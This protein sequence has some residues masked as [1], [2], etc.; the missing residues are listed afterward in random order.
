MDWRVSITNSARIQK[1]VR[2]E[3]TDFFRV[4][5]VPNPPSLDATLTAQD[6]EYTIR[7][8]LDIILCDCVYTTTDTTFTE[9]KNTQETLII[10]CIHSQGSEN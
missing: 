4:S 8:R 5:L 9:H 3:G 1:F 6:T 7:P 10:S 2:R